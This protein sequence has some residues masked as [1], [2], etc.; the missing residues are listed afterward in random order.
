MHTCVSRIS[1]H[2][3]DWSTR[4]L[5]GHNQSDK[6]N[7]DYSALC[8]L[9]GSCW[10]NILWNLLEFSLDKLINIFMASVTAVHFCVHLLKWP[11]VTLLTLNKHR[12]H[13]AGLCIVDN[14]DLNGPLQLLRG[15]SSNSLLSILL[16]ISSDPIQQVHRLKRTDCASW[17][18]TWCSQKKI[19]IVCIT[20]IRNHTILYSK[21]RFFY[22]YF[23]LDLTDA[24]VSI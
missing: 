2:G 3:Q 9:G 17:D 14:H 8:S 4:N 24:I 16:M 11:R 1:V 22:P 21:Q 15:L 10:G 5:R 6:A 20:R 18:R 12:S 19:H 23:L 13:G 7:R